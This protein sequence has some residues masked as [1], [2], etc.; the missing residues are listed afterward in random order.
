MIIETNIELGQEYEDALTGFRGIATGYV[1][2]ITGCD[3][4]CLDPGMGS[5]GK[6]LNSRYVDI[7][8]CGCRPGTRSA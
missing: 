2:Y 4:V 7:L 1:T 8:A 6:R 3:Q 5:D